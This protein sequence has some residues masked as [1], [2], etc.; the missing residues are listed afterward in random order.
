MSV[1]SQ[2]LQDIL[3]HDPMR[4][5]TL[6]LAALHQ[7]VTTP[8]ID[9]RPCVQPATPHQAV[10]ALF[11]ALILD[12]ELVLIDSDLSP[13]ETETMGISAAQQQQSVQLAGLPELQP[14]LIRQQC[15]AA[16]NFR[17]TL[18]TSG[19]T[20]LPK[21]VRHDLHSLSRT[22]KVSERQRNSVWGM[23]YNP[24]HIAGIQVLLQA[25]FN[26]NPLILLHT[27]APSVVHAQ[28]EARA[29]THLA[30]TPSFFR[31]L[32][33]VKRPFEGVRA[34]A[35][36]GEPANRGLI[37]LLKPGFPNARIRNLYGSTEAGTLLVAEGDCF[38]IPKEAATQVRI[39]DNELLIHHTAL[40]HLVDAPD[41]DE[42]WYHTGDIVEMHADGSFHF[43][44]RESEWIN[45]G[46]HK[47]D[48]AEVEAA[49]LS[50]PAVRQALVYPV[51]NSVLGEIPAAKVVLAPQYQAD[52]PSL[53][54]FLAKTLQSPKIPRKFEF[55]NDLPHTTTGKLDRKAQ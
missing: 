6:T 7:A 52:E 26:G 47:V 49:L 8:I 32:L 9:F 50:H 30:G 54:A 14:D 39:L 25:F 23:A 15:R 40:A 20:G 10:R 24:T 53:R 21:C 2:E 19:S 3:F 1:S 33:P 4:E 41:F 17:L 45:V 38:R 13:A 27:V 35:L 16:K 44:S 51:K 48:P 28:I 31:M 37:D 22:L 55:V 12:Q 36:G 46:G 18:H 42:G 11:V 5:E 29:I 34:I 43:A